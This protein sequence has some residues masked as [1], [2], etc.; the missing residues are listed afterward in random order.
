MVRVR[1][2]G[3][4]HAPALHA[5]RGAAH[6]SA[7]HAA[8]GAACACFMVCLQ[9]MSQL[10][11]PFCSFNIGCGPCVLPVHSVLLWC[12]R[13]SRARIIRCI[14]IALLLKKQGR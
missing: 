11:S 3:A 2:C 4:V 9:P 14:A 12:V 5:A 6:A 1:H 10:M 8:P 7:L 13:P